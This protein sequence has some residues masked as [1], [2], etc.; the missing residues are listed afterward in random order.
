MS[1]AIRL[2]VKLPLYGELA[3]RKVVHHMGHFVVRHV[4]GAHPTR[5][6]LAAHLTDQM[7]TTLERKYPA[8]D[9]GGQQ[10]GPV[11]PS[12]WVSTRTRATAADPA[13]VRVTAWNDHW[14]RQPA[15]GPAT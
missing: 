6:E 3:V 7:R 2:L 9:E 13:G 8:R 12:D 15:G 4:F 1:S 14:G 5:I 11:K 10:V